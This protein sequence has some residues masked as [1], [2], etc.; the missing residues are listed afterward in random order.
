MQASILVAP[1]TSEVQHIPE[2]N[3]E[4]DEVLIEVKACGVCASELHRWQHG[5]K[6]GFPQRMG[7]EPSGVVRTV[8]SNV[9]GWQVGDRVTALAPGKGA[10]AETISVHQD[11]VITLPDGVDFSEAI[12]EPVGCLVS[13][14]DRTAIRIADEVAIVG[15]GFMGLAL[16]QLV[17]WRGV[18]RII[19]I[20]PREEALAAARQFGA[21]E[22]I[23][24]ADVA[25]VMKCLGASRLQQGFDVVFETSGTQAG[26]TLAGD[27][28]T[29]HGIL[30]IVGWHA[31]GMREVNMSLW[32]YKAITVINAHERRMEQLVQYMA[33]GIH[34]I[35]A[36]KL[37]MSD[38]VTHHYTL[39][40]VDEA[41]AALESKPAGFI[42]AVI[43]P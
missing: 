6:Q 9:A 41:F 21:D 15:C 1:R 12:V 20:D 19:A 22:V 13:G 37:A 24:P 36:G 23:L 18:R 32:N 7:H 38:L 8:G 25:P 30:S 40:E 16:L 28:T 11:R 33:D 3:L 17:R 39:A 43:Y 42:K 34:M 26:L 10:F 29:V 14:L 35:A 4:P 2:P 27:M 5:G 31:D